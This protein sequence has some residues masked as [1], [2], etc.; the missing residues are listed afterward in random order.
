MTYHDD[1]LNKIESTLKITFIPNNSTTTPRAVL[2]NI[3][4][5][6]ITSFKQQT[7]LV[8][9]AFSNPLEISASNGQPD[10]VAL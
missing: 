6:S 5:F 8:Q 3:T 9:L 2:P 7:V 10:S 4:S 1:M